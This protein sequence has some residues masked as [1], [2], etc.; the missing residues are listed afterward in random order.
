MS[1][2]GRSTFVNRSL[3]LIP[4]SLDG[5]SRNVAGAAGRVAS[6]V[7]VSGGES[8]DSAQPGTVCRA[9]IT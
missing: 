6:I 4:E 5:L 8:T 7:I 9:V 2:D 1:N 3:L